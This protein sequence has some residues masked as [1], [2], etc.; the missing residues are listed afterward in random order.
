MSKHVSLKSGAPR[1]ISTIYCVEGKEVTWSGP[2]IINLL[3]LTLDQLMELR[4]GAFLDE[5]VAHS[6]LQY[7]LR[8]DR[9][10]MAMDTKNQRIFGTN[11]LACAEYLGR[12]PYACCS[13]TSSG[14]LARGKSNAS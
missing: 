2:D 6:N 4:W 12:R 11:P 13:Q 9:I 5:S 7:L 3:E 8:L 10:L 14:G 1:S